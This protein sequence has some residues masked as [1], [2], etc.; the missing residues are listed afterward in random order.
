MEKIE[1]YTKSKPVAANQP[2]SFPTNSKP[3]IV[4][5]ETITQNNIDDF[6]YTSPELKTVIPIANQNK[7]SSFTRDLNIS[8]PDIETII[9]TA[10][11]SLASENKWGTPKIVATDGFIDELIEGK[12]TAVATDVRQ[13]IVSE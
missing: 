9:Q 12:E 4:S 6:L 1:V 11:L 8:N 13:M 7:Q 3:P 5:L 10:C 2:S